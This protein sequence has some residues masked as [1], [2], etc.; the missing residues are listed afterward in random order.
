MILGRIGR[1]I[2]FVAGGIAVIIVGF[3]MLRGNMRMWDK[4]QDGED[5]LDDD[6][7]DND[8]NTPDDLGKRNT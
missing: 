5:A 1:L 6:N 7:N 4:P 2:L 3:F 8:D